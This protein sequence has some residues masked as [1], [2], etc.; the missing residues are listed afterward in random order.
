MSELV[1]QHNATSRHRDDEYNIAVRLYGRCADGK[2]VA[3]TVHGVSAYGFVCCS[4]DATFRERLS[5]C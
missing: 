3:L 5:Y 2:S 4:G 1:F